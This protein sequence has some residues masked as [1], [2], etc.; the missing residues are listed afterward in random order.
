MVS[1]SKRRRELAR[2]RYERQQARRTATWQ[3][4]QRRN[5]IAAIALAGVLV[6][7]GAIVVAQRVISDNR[8]TLA[9]GR[10]VYTASGT[11]A[12]DVGLPEFDP[13]VAAQP[14]TATL[15]TNRGDITFAALTDNAPCAT[16]SFRY[17]AENNYYDQS[18][19]PRVVNSPGFSLL[20]CG[21][22]TG[23]AADTPGYQF[24]D[25]NLTDA[26]YPAG[27]IAMANTGQPNSNGSQFFIVYQD[28]EELT[29]NYTPFGTVTSGLA[30]A[31]KVGEAGNDGSNPAGGGNPK[32]PITITDVVI[33]PA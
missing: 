30:V 32:L 23:S 7:S 28:S 22:P 26:T 3:R 9:A 5:R 29:A 6:I 1:G 12:S 33:S 8:T 17:L 27:A 11:P 21:T 20:Q 13:E 14:Y 10:C 31:A 4:K 15:K 19:C 24:P 18:S 25:E 2:Q 16:Y